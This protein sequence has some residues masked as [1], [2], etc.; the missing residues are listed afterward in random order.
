[1]PGVK[2]YNTIGSAA[3][4]NTKPADTFS[5]RRFSDYC[6]RFFFFLNFAVEKKLTLRFKRTRYD[7]NI[8]YFIVWMKKLYNASKKTNFHIKPPLAQ[9]R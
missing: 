3:R 2:L 1:M 8:L 9:T 4:I 6:P 5:T 7:L